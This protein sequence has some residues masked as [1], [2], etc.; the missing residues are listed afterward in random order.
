MASIHIRDE[1][2]RWTKDADY[3]SLVSA[4]FAARRLVPFLRIP[5]AWIRIETMGGHPSGTFRFL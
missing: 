1:H 2:G 3:N 4:A 5:V